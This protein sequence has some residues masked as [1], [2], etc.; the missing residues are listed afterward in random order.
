VTPIRVHCRLA[1]L[2]AVCALVGC[3]HPQSGIAVQT[4]PPAL[5][6]VETRTVGCYRFLAPVRDLPADLILLAR[7]G[8]GAGPERFGR[9]IRPRGRYQSAYWRQARGD[10]LELTWTTT[11]SDSAGKPGTV[12]FMDALRARVTLIRDTLSGR[13]NWA[14]DVL[15]APGMPTSFDFRARRV[16]CPDGSS[17]E[18]PNE[19]VE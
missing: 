17:R 3:A 13:A 19:D 15:D 8:Q 1:N 11:P 18:L 16:S 9:L 12:I 5:T 7:H 14:A 6:A 4:E 2:C 10:T